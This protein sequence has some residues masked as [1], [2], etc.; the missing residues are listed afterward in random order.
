MK[1]V[2]YRESG[3]NTT[4]DDSRSRVLFNKKRIKPMNNSEYIEK[5]ISQLQSDEGTER[6]R[7]R[8]ALVRIGKPAVP[9][10]VDLLTH[11]NDLLRWEAC[12]ALG[13][14]SDPGTAASLVHA[15]SDSSMEIRWL[16][17]EALISLG[18]DAVNELLRALEINFNSVFLREGA[19]HVLHALERQKLLD[20][21]TLNVLDSLRYLQPSISVGVAAKEALESL[22]QH[23]E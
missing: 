11:E 7:A 8:K 2:S 13:S 22:L 12:K 20:K 5:L 10:L 18:E 1:T 9:L 3:S 16:A 17:G 14:I 21:K 15:L 19:H 6:Q 4:G 23:S